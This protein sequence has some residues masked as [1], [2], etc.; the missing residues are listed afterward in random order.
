MFEEVRK[1]M[2]VY[3]GRRERMFG[4]AHLYRLAS[5]DDEVLG[6]LHHEACKLVAEDAF[7]LVR[8]LDL[9]AESDRVNG[10]FDEY[11]FV[12]VAGDRQWVEEYFL[13]RS[14]GLQ[15]DDK[16]VMQHGA[17]PASTSGTL[18][19]STTYTR[20][21]RRHSRPHAGERTCDE[22]FSRV[23]AAVSV[24]RTAARYGLSELLYPLIISLGHQVDSSDAHHRAGSGQA[25][26]Q[27][28]RRPNAEARAARSAAAHREIWRARFFLL[29]TF[30]IFITKWP[31]LSVSGAQILFPHDMQLTERVF[32]SLSAI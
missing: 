19:R 24:E 1:Q 20:V 27:S 21:N 28:K 3:A 5:E 14:E 25:E 23:S 15:S 8:L 7:D 17:H 29:S 16:P 11:P 12:L 6:A 2:N 32:L 22:K 4:A 9:D 26:A 30:I 10:W 13:R 31:L 18:C